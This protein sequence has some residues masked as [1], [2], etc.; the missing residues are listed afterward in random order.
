[1]I[2]E[3]GKKK[4]KKGIEN[5]QSGI[6]PGRPDQ[7]NPTRSANA[8]NTFTGS[9]AKGDRE[10]NEKKNQRGVFK[11]FPSLCFPFPQ[12]VATSNSIFPW[13]SLRG[14]MGFKEQ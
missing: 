2:I 6:S 8:N 3:R 10:N 9:A 5:S 1:M 12:L 11:F 4:H 13:I 14:D 7:T